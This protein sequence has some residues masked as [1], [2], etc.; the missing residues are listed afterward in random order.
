VVT[1]ESR[2]YMSLIGSGTTFLF[3]EVYLGFRFLVKVWTKWYK[4]RNLFF[5]DFRITPWVKKT[6]AEGSLYDK[7]EPACWGFLLIIDIF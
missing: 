6:P 7:E 2:P 4:I 3:K 1:R 5:A